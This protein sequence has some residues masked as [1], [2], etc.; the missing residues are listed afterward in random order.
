[1][2]GKKTNQ[3]EERL[4]TKPWEGEMGAGGEFAWPLKKQQKR[5]PCN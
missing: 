4:S 2:T 1:M 3:T 5:G